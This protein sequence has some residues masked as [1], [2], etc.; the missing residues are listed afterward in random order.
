MGR[1]WAAGNKERRDPSY[2]EGAFYPQKIP[3]H[4]ELGRGTFESRNARDRLGHPPCLF[5]GLSSRRLSLRKLGQARELVPDHFERFN[6]RILLIVH[7][8]NRGSCFSGP[9]H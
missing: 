8:G 1:E 6:C 9:Q 7:N 5:E 2:G 3:A 4:A